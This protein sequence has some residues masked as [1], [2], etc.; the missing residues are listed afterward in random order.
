MFDEHFNPPP[1]VY[2]LVP[3]IIVPKPTDSTG[4]PSLTT[5]NQDALSP[6]TSQETQ[7]LVIPSSVK[8]QFHNIEVAHLDND[9][10][11]GVLILELN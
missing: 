8:E 3:A 2:S 7:S 4:T 9:P 11:F 1:S 10:F 5:I 6:S